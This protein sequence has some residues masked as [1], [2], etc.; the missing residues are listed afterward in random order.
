MKLSDEFVKG[1]RFLFS[2]LFFSEDDN[3]W[4]CFARHLTMSMY[5]PTGNEVYIL[6]HVLSGPSMK[7][8]WVKFDPF[9]III[10]PKI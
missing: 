3:Y 2:F 4:E 7:H 8:E 1:N 6:G 10:C 5:H 9:F